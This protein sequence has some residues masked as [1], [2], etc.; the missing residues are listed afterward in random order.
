MKNILFL[1][2]YNICSHNFRQQMMQL[3]IQ[4]MKNK[5]KEM[6][7][8]LALG[9]TIPDVAFKTRRFTA[10]VVVTYDPFPDGYYR[11]FKIG[12][13]ARKRYEHFDSMADIA[14]MKY[15][16]TVSM[17]ASARDYYHSKCRRKRWM[18]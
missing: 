5:E 3:T 17:Y 4:K 8:L 6:G 1:D 9:A 2:E 15:P 13:S 14:R 10:T 7:M 11:H 16:E 12:K 18:K